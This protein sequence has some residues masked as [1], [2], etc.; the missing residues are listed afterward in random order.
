MTDSLTQ[1]VFFAPRKRKPASCPFPP[2]DGETD[3]SWAALRSAAF[4]SF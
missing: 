3:A 4:E 2:L 1:A